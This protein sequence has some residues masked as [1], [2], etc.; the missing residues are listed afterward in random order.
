MLTS[1][2]IRTGKTIFRSVYA[3]SNALW[4]VVEKKG[5]DC[6]LCRI[7]NEPIEING[8]TYSGDYA[9]VEKVFMRDEIKRHLH[10]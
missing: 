8:I 2:K 4:R 7:E 10:S 9:G 3:D 1:L 6:Y 5:K